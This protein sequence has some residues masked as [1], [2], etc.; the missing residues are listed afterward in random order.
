MDFEDNMP[1]YMQIVILMK[2]R[3]IQGSLKSGDKMPSVRELAEEL[4]VNPNTI[5]RSYQE[6]EKQKITETKR[7]MGT[8]ISGEENMMETIRSEFS[9]NM[10]T[11]FIR[12]MRETG[13]SD[14][15][16]I[17]LL[18]TAIHSEGEEK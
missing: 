9:A 13:F 10:V 1:I 11:R 6:L 8:F 5:S 7:G 14:Q 4:K 15:E 2:K 17:K 3:I 16:I 12:D 18:S